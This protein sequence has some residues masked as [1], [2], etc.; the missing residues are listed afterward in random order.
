VRIRAAAEAFIEDLCAR[1]SS[2]SLLRQTRRSLARL[3]SHLREMGVCELRQV[4]ERHLVA[5]AR[6]L[7]LS[8]G[9][10]G[11]PLSLATQ[12]SYL[13]PVRSFFAFLERRGLV[14][15]RPEIVIPRA[16]PL[17]RAV[18]SVSQAARLMQ[19]PLIGT[20]V[21]ERNRALLE[22][23]YGTGIRR[24]ECARL[25]VQDLDLQERTLL[26]RDGK[27]HKDRMLPV[28]GRAAEALSNYLGH[29]RPQLV[30]DPSERAVFLTAWWGR[31][32]SDVSLG[33]IVRHH[34]KAAGVPPVHPHALRHACATHLLKGGADLRHVQALLGHKRLTT[35]CIY[36]R[37]VVEDL[38]E[39][40]ARA[41]PREMAWR[42]R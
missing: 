17:P 14:L 42:R 1:R 8:K 18:L 2:S 5:L 26:I 36:T 7:R 3:S 25:N 23:L 29:V 39:V 34:A 13:Q 19:A 9:R 35:T 24:G 33:V 41:H 30:R 38:R 4:E 21:G 27:G 10:D 6:K 20:K 40:L 37:V 32:L 28:P 15:S 16:S 12:A 22:L 31:R 11:A